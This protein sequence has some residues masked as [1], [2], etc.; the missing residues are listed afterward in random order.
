MR[1]RRGGHPPA[2]SLA[3]RALAYVLDAIVTL[4]AWGLVV[5]SL[6]GFAP[7]RLADEPTLGAVAGLLFYAIP[8]AYFVLAEAATGTTVGKR[9]V[10][11]HVR[12]LEDRRP[13]LFAA[14]VRNTLRLAW[15][16]GVAGPAFL[17]ADAVLVQVTER[18]QR[19]GDLAA[20]T[21]VVRE[22]EAPL[23]L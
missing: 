18:D 15:A 8:F 10:G 2:A 19:V 16:L 4:L 12:D 13:G 22:G 20:E 11:L 21:V 1:T 6:T 3:E 17:A 14:T 7:R 5:G 9:L 23:S